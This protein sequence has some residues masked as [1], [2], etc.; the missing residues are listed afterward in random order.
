MCNNLWSMDSDLIVSECQTFWLWNT[1][2][3]SSLEVPD[4]SSRESKDMGDL[5]QGGTDLAE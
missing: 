3:V 2:Q 5:M 4:L 1:L